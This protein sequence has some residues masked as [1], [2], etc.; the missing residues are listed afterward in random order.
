MVESC[1]ASSSDDTTSVV[2]EGIG[3]SV[4]SNRNWL[5][6]NRAHNV[7]V[8]LADNNVV[9]SCA[10]DSLDNTKGSV[11]IACASNTEVKG[12][13]RVWVVSL[14]LL[15]VALQIVPCPVVPATTAAGISVA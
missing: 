15:S 5:L 12:I 14:S 3:R 4:N 7:R 10:S 11:G 6:V 13:E 8:I 9:I 2:L 1:A